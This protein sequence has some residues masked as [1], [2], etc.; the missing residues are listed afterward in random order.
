ML[1]PHR[2]ALLFYYFNHLYS[3]FFFNHNVFF[4]FG[5]SFL[6]RD[7]VKTASYIPKREKFIC[8]SQYGKNSLLYCNL[9]K[10]VEGKI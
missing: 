8:E 3:N 1:A 6:Y 5:P 10:E 4:H 2:G 7:T 9:Q